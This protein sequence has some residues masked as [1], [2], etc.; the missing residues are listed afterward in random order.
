MK[1][2]FINSTN[3]KHGEPSNVMFDCEGYSTK[4][5]AAIFNY[6]M[7]ELKKQ[8]A[9]KNPIIQPDKLILPNG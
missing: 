6:V 5:V 8:E 7:G 9:K 2:L 4:E 1:Y 3:K